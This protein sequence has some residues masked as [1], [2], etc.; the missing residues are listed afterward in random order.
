MAKKSQTS[1]LGEMFKDSLFARSKQRKPPVVRIKFID[2]AN[3][4]YGHIWSQ[5]GYLKPGPDDTLVP[6][7]F[8][9]SQCGLV[10]VLRPLWLGDQT[11]QLYRGYIDVRCPKESD[12]IKTLQQRKGKVILTRPLRDFGLLAGQECDIVPC[13]PEDAQK[14][15]DQPW[16][17]SPTRNEPV[18]LLDGEY[19][20][21][22]QNTRRRK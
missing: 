8:T 13:P 17:W 2:M 1:I 11:I 19:K 10:G 6:R 5:T 15:G 22:N 20:Y 12:M 18:R 21:V 4:P 7:V 14:Y 3:N 9:C 16:V